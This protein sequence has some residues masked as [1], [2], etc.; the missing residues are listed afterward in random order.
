[1][2]TDAELVTAVAVLKEFSGDP[3]AGIVRELIDA[4]EKSVNPVKEVR[5]VSAKETR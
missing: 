5:V 3:D 4:I 2:F 1:V